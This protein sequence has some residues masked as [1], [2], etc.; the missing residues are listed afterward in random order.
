MQLRED[1]KELTV[2]ALEKV[3]AMPTRAILRNSRKLPSCKES[4][5][6]TDE[7]NQRQ[8]CVGRDILSK[9]TFGTA[10]DM[11]SLIENLNGT[12]ILDKTQFSATIDCSDQT[13]FCSSRG[14][15]KLTV[16]SVRTKSSMQK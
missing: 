5:T 12:V 16:L 8:F 4:G 15:A 13:T 14:V 11:P 3:A 9:E 7:P 2:T 10:S 1:I 6:S